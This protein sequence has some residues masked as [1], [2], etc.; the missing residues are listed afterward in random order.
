[1][2]RVNNGPDKMT[3]LM[4]GNWLTMFPYLRKG[5]KYQVNI[6]YKYGL[7]NLHKICNYIQDQ[8]NYMHGFTTEMLRRSKRTVVYQYQGGML[9][10]LGGYLIHFKPLGLKFAKC[11][12]T[13][14]RG[15]EYNYQVHKVF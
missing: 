8:V 9:D 4:S 12:S 14:T 1:M 10:C 15:K 6:K 3:Y 2:S 7:V 5:R 13:A 11:N